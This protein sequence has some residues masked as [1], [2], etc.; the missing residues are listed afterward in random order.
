MLIIVELC[1]HSGSGFVP[2]HGR[3]IHEFWVRSSEILINGIEKLENRG[4][5]IYTHFS[6][7]CT[8]GSPM[9]YL[10]KNKIDER[11]AKYWKDFVKL[12]RSA[13]RIFR[14]SHTCSLELSRACRY[15]RTIEM[16][17]FLARHNL[18]V[19]TYF[20]RCSY[21]ERQTQPLAKHTYRFQFQEPI[22]AGRY[23]QCNQHKPLSNQDLEQEG[24]Y[25]KAMVLEI[26][27]QI[28]RLFN[29]KP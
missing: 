19:C 26:T 27:C 8:G 11:L 12:L 7:P 25:P 24:H 28:A 13:D 15:W 29:R 2:V 20:H 5:R 6:P 16:H 17:K 14:E 1:T 21:Q 4:C 22:I 9:Q 3:S 10:Q 18:Q 23:C